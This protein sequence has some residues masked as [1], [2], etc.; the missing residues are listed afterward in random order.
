MA[1]C[2]QQ[3]PLRTYSM[4]RP[5]LNG[6]CGAKVRCLFCGHWA[7][8]KL[9]LAEET[10]KMVTKENLWFWIP[11]IWSDGESNAH[12]WSY[13]TFCR[14]IKQRTHQE[15]GGFSRRIGCYLCSSSHSELPSSS[16]CMVESVCSA[17]DMKGA[18]SSRRFGQDEI[19]HHL[20]S[21][22]SIASLNGWRTELSMATSMHRTSY[23]KTLA[24]CLAE[25]R[26]PKQS[27]EANHTG[28]FKRE[29]RCCCWVTKESGM[30]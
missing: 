28:E 9:P 3:E 19:E 5:I 15:L 21:P 11:G 29:F 23:L 12:I 13:D 17:L 4:K 22:R 14:A 24:S 26:S 7:T 16:A 25:A 18:W 10:H 8:G 2:S 1:I 6:T 20:P 27:R 30:G